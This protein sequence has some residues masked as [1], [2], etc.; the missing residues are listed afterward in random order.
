M[1]N[2]ILCLLLLS[3]VLCSAMNTAI[4]QVTATKLYWVQSSGTAA[5]DRLVRSDLDGTNITTL[6]SDVANFNN[7]VRLAVDQARSRIY[8]TDQPAGTGPILRFDLTGGS[9]TVIAATSASFT[10][11][12][13]AVAGSYIYWVQ[14]SGT[15]ANDQL[16]RADLD[17][18][19]VTVLAAGASNFNNPV[20]LTVD[21]AHQYIYVADQPAA[22]GVGIVRFDLTGGNRTVVLHPTLVT[23]ITTCRWPVIFY[24]GCRVP[25]LPQMTNW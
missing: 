14:S 4:S 20:N 8:I 21:L 19:N 13:I 15:A 23:P 22:T 6:A 25:V 5:N 2:K 1:K 18:S 7:P 24:T 17:G 3:G 9:R 16:V 10:Y 12:D 11:N